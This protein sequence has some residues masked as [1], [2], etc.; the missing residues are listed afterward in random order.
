MR[1]IPEQTYGLIE[2]CLS[3]FIFFSP[4]F[5]LFIPSL[6]DKIYIMLLYNYFI[7]FILISTV[8]HFRFNIFTMREEYE[9]EQKEKKQK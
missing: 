9:K 1:I 7:M 8:S 2:N 3:A 5:L 6:S 4:N